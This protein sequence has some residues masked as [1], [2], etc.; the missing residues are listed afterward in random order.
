MAT[1]AGVGAGVGAGADAFTSRMIGMRP[2]V[3]IS[4]PD[5]A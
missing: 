2:N 4:R 3:A 5:D 1:S